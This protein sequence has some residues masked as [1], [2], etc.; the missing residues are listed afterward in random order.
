MRNAA[1]MKDITAP[2]P[3]TPV[4]ATVACLNGE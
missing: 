4:K 2:V 3:R 1:N